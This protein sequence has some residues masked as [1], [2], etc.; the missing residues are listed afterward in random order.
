MGESLGGREPGSLFNNSIGSLFTN[1][2][3]KLVQRNSSQMYLLGHKKV[4]NTL[5][6]NI[7]EHQRVWM[8]VVQIQCHEESKSR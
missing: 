3:E 5:Q 4:F 6:G 7:S 2:G 8:V 1:S